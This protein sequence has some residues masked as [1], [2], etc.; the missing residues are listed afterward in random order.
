MADYAN[1]QLKNYIP[2]KDIDKKIIAGKF[3]LIK[4]TWRNRTGWF[5]ETTVG[6]KIGYLDSGKDSRMFET[7]LLWNWHICYI[8]FPNYTSVGPSI[9]INLVHISKTLLNNPSESHLSG[10]KIRSQLL[11]ILRSKNQSVEV[12]KGG[13][14]KN[15]SFCKGILP[16]QN[17]KR[18]GKKRH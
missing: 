9:I 2:D 10:K 13:N 4:S 7:I 1:F 11:E 5:W 15:T 8:D 12:F 17:E 6:I 3:R 16:Y 14:D 18:Q